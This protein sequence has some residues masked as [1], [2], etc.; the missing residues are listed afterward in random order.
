MQPSNE[1]KTKYISSQI[2]KMAAVQSSKRRLACLTIVN[3][4]KALKEID[5]GQSCI[6]TAKKYGVAKNTISHRVKKKAEIFE[7][8]EE[9]KALKK[10]KKN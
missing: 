1:N 2:S 4:Y 8:V 7:A 5:A 6:A 3:K 10:G 9:N